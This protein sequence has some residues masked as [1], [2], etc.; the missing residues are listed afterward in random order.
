MMRFGEALGTL[1][2]TTDRIYL[3]KS[4]K[5]DLTPEEIKEMESGKFIVRRKR[6]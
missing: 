4:G 5:F 1:N 2:L 3:M 6:K